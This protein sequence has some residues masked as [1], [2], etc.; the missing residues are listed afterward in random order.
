VLLGLETVVQ[1]AEEL[2]EQVALSSDMPVAT[3][4]SY[5]VVASTREIVLD[6]GPRPNVACC[7][8][9]VVLCATITNVVALARGSRDR[10][11]AGIRLERARV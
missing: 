8:D 7:G 4:S 11:S 9:S 6:R 3:A 5:L 2:I 10:S 1:L